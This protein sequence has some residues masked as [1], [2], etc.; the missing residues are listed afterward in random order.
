MKDKVIRAIPGPNPNM[1]QVIL[2]ADPE[3]IEIDSLRTAIMVIDMQNAFCSKGG[4]F[5]LWGNDIS[6][7][8]RIIKPIQRIIGIAHLKGSKVIYTAS[9]LSSDLRELG[10]PDSAISYKIGVPSS[11]RE[12]PEWKDILTFRGTW[13]ADII[14]ELKLQDGD[15]LVEKSMRSAF[16][17]TNLDMILKTF[18]IRYLAFV[19]VATNVCVESTIRDA[20][21]LGYWPILISD[22]C[23]NTGP[24]FI[25]EATI[26]NVKR[27]FGWVTTSQN[28]LQALQ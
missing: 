23:A 16:F 15:I 4:M 5:D 28:L 20:S 13:G 24:P 17:A 11:C 7:S 2:R 22:A 12:H 1:A 8:Q 26:F 10:D 19:G 18:K 27:S 14:Q 21:Y 9:V 25:Q 6:G 3:S